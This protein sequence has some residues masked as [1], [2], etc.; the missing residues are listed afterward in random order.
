MFFFLRCCS[1]SVSLVQ[2]S[3]Q[4]KPVIDPE[5]QIKSTAAAQSQ[6]DVGCVGVLG[7]LLHHFLLFQLCDGDQ[8]KHALCIIL[9]PHAISLI[10]GF[11]FSL[12]VFF[13]FL[14]QKLLL[15]RDKYYYKSCIFVRLWKV[16]ISIQM[17]WY[18][19]LYSTY[20]F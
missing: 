15:A 12:Y 2:F 4:T 17:L 14:N 7:C 5:P 13:F 10:K 1:R 11:C 3:E 8:V 9:R 19:L 20:H 16:Y 18:I 6:P